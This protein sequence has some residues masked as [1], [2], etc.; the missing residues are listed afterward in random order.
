METNLLSHVKT[1]LFIIIQYIYFNA[2][3]QNN[4]TIMYI[5]VEI[6]QAI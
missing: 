3:I 4:N 6:K 1:L 5:Y 2:V